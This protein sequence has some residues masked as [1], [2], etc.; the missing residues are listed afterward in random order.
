MKPALL[1][2][3]R[4]RAAFGTRV[5]LVDGIGVEL[6]E[7]FREAKASYPPSWF[8]AGPPSEHDANAFRALVWRI[9]DRRF[10]DL[11]R[12]HYV[13]TKHIEDQEAAQQFQAEQ[14]LDARRFLH[15]LA[16]LVDSLAD[17]DRELLGRSTK[18]QPTPMTDAERIR[19]HRLR[20]K[21]AQTIRDRIKDPDKS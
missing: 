1:S 9:A 21:L 19:L 10:L 17:E 5:D 20:Q 6:A 13:R 8:S 12:A 2:H 4:G 7:V 3:F 16:E 18:G 14:Q 11:L 15:V